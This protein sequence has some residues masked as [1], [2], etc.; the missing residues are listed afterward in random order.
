[1]DNSHQ[2]QIRRYLEG[3]LPI[4]EEA[5]LL[6]WLRE[7]KEN[8]RQFRAAESEWMRTSSPSLKARI[9]V[10]KARGKAR[11]AIFRTRTIAAVSGIAAAIAIFGV[12][13]LT[14]RTQGGVNI[15]PD[16]SQAFCI[17]V[18]L[19]STSEIT[20]PDGTK[21]VLNSGS[22][23]NYDRRFNK[24]NRDIYLS[25]EAYFDV[26]H[27]ESL[28]FVVH[29]GKC[30]LTVLGTRF[31]VYAYEDE[32][33]AYAA[34]ME[35]SLK[36]DAGSATILISPDEVVSYDGSSI[37]KTITETD[38]YLSW[39]GGEIR[40][41][42]IGLS[43]FLHRISRLYDIPVS[44]SGSG[45]DSRKFR[46]AF[47]KKDSLGQVLEAVSNLLPIKATKTGDGYEVSN[48]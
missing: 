40:Y 17:N 15:S 32:D 25:G 31:D 38:Q 37:T 43:E 21:V 13:S 20:L 47:T 5:D 7:S 26:V 27:N 9:A 2:D 42:E 35:G 1:M 8:I 23:L 44:Y 45:L 18:P 12:L 39:I 19:S 48:L 36:M 4:S 22:S 33:V 46:A 29:T 24:K 3:S 6:Q 14:S 16:S 28:P 30:D 10:A 11:K 41:D 34:L